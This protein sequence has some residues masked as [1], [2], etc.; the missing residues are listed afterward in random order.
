MGV[1]S[2]RSRW[3]DRRFD[4]SVIDWGKCVAVVSVRA[5]IEGWVEGAN[6]GTFANASGFPVG[7]RVKDLDVGFAEAVS[8]V[9]SV[10]HDCRFVVA[11]VML[12]C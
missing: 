6:I 7:I 2:R 11:V 1:R 4:D 9:S 12:S 10:L 5:P 8:C 3:L